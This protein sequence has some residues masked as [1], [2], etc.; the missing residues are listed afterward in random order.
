MQQNYV[1]AAKL[2]RR[3]ADQGHADAQCN[4]GTLYKNGQGV[5][6]DLSISMSLFE[7][8][9]DRGNDRAKLA[10]ERLR[11]SSASQPS[12]SLEPSRSPGD[13]CAQC[14]A[15]SSIEKPLKAC[16]RCGSVFYC[17]RSCQSA[18]WKAGHKRSCKPN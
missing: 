13:V 18:H 7:K 4:L 15:K 14:A 5:Q 16:A 12:S 3:A 2:Y 8:A 17:G 10:L 11:L 1:E 6:Q 9:A